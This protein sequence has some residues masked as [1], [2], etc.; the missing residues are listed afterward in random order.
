M[1]IRRKYTIPAACLVFGLIALGLGVWH[2][3]DG[4][5]AGFVIGIAVVLVYYV[6]MYVGTA[7]AKGHMVPRSSRCGFP[8]WCW[9]ALAWCCWCSRREATNSPPPS[10]FQIPEALARLLPRGSAEMSD[11]ATPSSHGQRRVVG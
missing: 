10:A 9:A 3:K 4:K 8:I 6:L 5:N 1:A 11:A 7:L 2:R